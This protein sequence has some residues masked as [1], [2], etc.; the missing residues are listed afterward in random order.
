MKK[1]SYKFAD[2]A[3]KERAGTGRPAKTCWSCY[4][5]GLPAGRLKVNSHLEI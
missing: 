3:G 5:A 1:E 4:S 2:L